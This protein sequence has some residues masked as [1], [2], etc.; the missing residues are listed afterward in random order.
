MQE[1][2]VA[3]PAK[4]PQPPSKI[5][6]NNLRWPI[7]ALSTHEEE[8]ILAPEGINKLHM[9]DLEAA[10]QLLDIDP[11]KLRPPGYRTNRN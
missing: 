4:Q 1:I 6:R 8:S 9:D 3:K 2:D 11:Y 10:V 5:Y 7:K